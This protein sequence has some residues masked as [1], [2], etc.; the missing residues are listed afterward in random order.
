MLCIMA[1]NVDMDVI[2]EPLSTMLQVGDAL[3]APLTIFLLYLN[4]VLWEELVKVNARLTRILFHQLKIRD[5]DWS[6]DDDLP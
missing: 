3:Q 6:D 5:K 2:P 1:G 4:W